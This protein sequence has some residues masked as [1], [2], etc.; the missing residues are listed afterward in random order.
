MLRTYGKVIGDM[1]IALLGYAND[2]GHL[3]SWISKNVAM[4]IFSKLKV[5][6]SSKKYIT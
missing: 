5:L 6:E 3:F 4:A 1:S 2:N